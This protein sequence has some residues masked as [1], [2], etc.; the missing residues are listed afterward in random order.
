MRRF[1]VLVAIFAVAGAGASF[2]LACGGPDKPP[3][4]PD[5][6]DPTNL[7]ADEAGAPSTPATP[8]TGSATPAK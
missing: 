2:A 7:G 8:A 3:L 4:T 6:P 5:G 1:V